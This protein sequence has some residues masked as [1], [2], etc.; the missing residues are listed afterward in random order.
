MDLFLFGLLYMYRGDYNDQILYMMVFFAVSA[1]SI[2]FFISRF[3]FGDRYIFLICS[4]LCMIGVC[5]IS[6][7]D[8]ELGFIQFTWYIVGFFVFIFCSVIFYNFNIWYKIQWIYFSVSMVLF[9]LTFVYGKVIFGAKNWLEIFGRVFQPSEVIKL[10]YIFFLSCYFCKPFKNKI[11]NI[12]E[13][14]VVFF[15]SMLFP[16]LLILQREW[17][18]A[19]LLFLLYFF[20]VYVYNGGGIVLITSVFIMAASLFW[21]YN[22]LNHLQVRIEAWLDPFSDP[23]GRGYQIVQ[24]LFAI[25]AG[26]FFGRGLGNG[27]PQ[28]VPNISSDFIFSAICE[29]FGILSGMAVILLYFIAVYRFFRISIAVGGFNK[30]VS[31]GLA[32]MFALQTFII[33]GGVIKFIPLTGITMPFVSYGGTSVVLCFA[34]LGILQALSAKSV[35]FFD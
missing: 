33:I 9:L 2:Y 13:R 7:I 10:L 3:S 34:A 17:G 27:S 11:S 35:V 26:G 5:M 1:V 19:V 30:S 25:A 6:R 18:T 31:F 24:S 8:L 22:N 29:E 15:A 12:N 28:F 32:V 23:A 21:G 20:Y 14:Y 4:V 16:V